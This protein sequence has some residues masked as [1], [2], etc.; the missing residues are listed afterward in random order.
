LTPFKL[1][2]IEIAGV[3]IDEKA[4]LFGSFLAKL[5]K[6]GIEIDASDSGFPGLP[7]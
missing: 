1:E 6:I 3:K 5:N 2:S 4:F 7:R